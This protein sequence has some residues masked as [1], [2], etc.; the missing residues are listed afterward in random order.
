MQ[1][2]TC[3]TSIYPTMIPLDLSLHMQKLA[4][5]DESPLPQLTP[6]RCSACVVYRLAAPNLYRGQSAR[7]Y[8]PFCVH[9]LQGGGADWIFTQISI[10]IATT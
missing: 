9:G 3:G 5:C 4:R 1:V 6:S 2:F 8:A 10:V 7:F